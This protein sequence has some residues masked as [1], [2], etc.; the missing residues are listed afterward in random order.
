M[1][2]SVIVVDKVLEIFPFVFINKLSHPL[3]ASKD[4][5]YREG[6]TDA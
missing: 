2:G 6:G 1:R 3:S 4:I 5:F